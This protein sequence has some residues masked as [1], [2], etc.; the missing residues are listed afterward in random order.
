LGRIGGPGAA[1]ALF[2]AS[3]VNVPWIGAAPLYALAELRDSRAVEPL[4]SC[5]AAGD[6]S[7]AYYL[8]KVGNE[9]ALAHLLKLLTSTNGQVRFNAAKALGELASPGAV[10][11]LIAATRE[12][13]G[14]M[15]SSGGWLYEE[16]DGIPLGDIHGAEGAMGGAGAFC[17]QLPMTDDYAR[18]RW[19]AARALGRIG[20]PQTVAALLAMLKDDPKDQNA[21]YYVAEALARLKAREGVEPLAALLEKRD[22]WPQPGWMLV[23]AL[24]E[25]GDERAAGALRK[26]LVDQKGD[27]QAR[28]L[29]LWAL[30]KVGESGVVERCQKDLGA[31]EA[32]ARRAA[33]EALG[34]IGERSAFEPLVTALRDDDARVRS[35]AAKGLGLLGNPDAGP[36]L[37]AAVDDHVE[38]VRFWAMVALG[39]LADERAI[40]ALEKVFAGQR[41]HLHYAAYWALRQIEARRAGERR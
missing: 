34:M 6:G 23:R 19:H 18:A 31:D 13:S 2:A 32:L 29:I 20:G 10:D 7:A 16:W 12:R 1:E 30:W 21:P 36:A 25:L 24:G 17:G 40:P 9:A 41:L 35:A 37:A 8:G 11:A 3:K 26:A 14:S 39:W 22:F 28:A 27:G 33:A 5:A 4:A 38:A 15:N